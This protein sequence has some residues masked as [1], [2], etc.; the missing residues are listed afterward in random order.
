MIGGSTIQSDGTN[1]GDVENHKTL[2]VK[3]SNDGMNAGTKTRQVLRKKGGRRLR[4]TAPRHQQKSE[5][6]GQS[7]RLTDH[8]NNKNNNPLTA[9]PANNPALG[10]ETTGTLSALS[11]PHLKQESKKEVT[12]WLVNIR[13]ALVVGGDSP[14]SSSSPA[15]LLPFP[16]HSSKICDYI[17]VAPEADQ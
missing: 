7:A 15:Y 5:R 6:N 9:A 17:P 11:L 10:T 12:S 13:S 1:V 3:P 4:A 8:N 2:S 16:L 14:V